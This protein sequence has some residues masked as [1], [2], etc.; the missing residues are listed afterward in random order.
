MARRKARKT[1]RNITVAEVQDA[2]RSYFRMRDASNEVWA[3]VKAAGKNPACSM[4]AIA[5]YTTK[6]QAFD[7]MNEMLNAAHD[8]GLEIPEEV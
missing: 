3:E 8:A 7:L 6:M 1:A 4:K 2:R 5:Y